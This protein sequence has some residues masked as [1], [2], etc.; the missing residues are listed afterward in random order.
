MGLRGLDPP[1]RAKEAYCV[2]GAPFDWNEEDLRGLLEKRNFTELE[3][4]SAPRTK[5]QAWLFSAK[6]G[7]EEQVLMIDGQYVR[8]R[9]RKRKKK[10]KY[11]VGQRIS[12]PGWVWNQAKTNDQEMNVAEQT[13]SAVKAENDQ[14]GAEGDE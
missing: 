11:E 10:M 13:E 2:V 6:A 14:G 1:P 5:Q 8:I 7:K 3:Y 12:R 9:P 4:F